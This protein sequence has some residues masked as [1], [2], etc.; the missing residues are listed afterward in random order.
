MSRRRMR[1]VEMTIRPDPDA[2]PYLLDVACTTCGAASAPMPE[3]YAGE[4][5]DTAEDWALAHTGKADAE[6]RHHTGYRV[7]VTMFWRVT[8]HEEI[9]PPE[10]ESSSGPGAEGPA[11]RAVAPPGPS[12][13]P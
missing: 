1:F 7:T 3:R 10:P 2:E 5:R 9:D 4:R 12:P 8:P 11:T 6:G 13:A